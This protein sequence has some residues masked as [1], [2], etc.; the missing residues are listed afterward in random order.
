[1]ATLTAAE[2]KTILESPVSPGYPANQ[3]EEINAALMQNEERRKYPSIDVQNI[4]GQE[5]LKDFPTKTTGQTFL[6][7]LFYRYRSFGEQHEPDIKQYE[8][9]IFN[10]IDQAGDFAVPGVK[11][12][13]SQSWKRDSETFPVH[14]SHSILTVTAENIEATDGSGIPG[15]KIEI[16]IGGIGPLTVISLATDEKSINKQLDLKDDAER[17]FTKISNTDLLVVEVELTKS[18]EITMAGLV[19]AGDDIS[20]VLVKDGST[21]NL[22]ANLSNSIASASRD[23]VQ[24]T[25]VSMDIKN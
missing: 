4:T 13:V 18:T 23:V 8:D 22:T 2:I 9:A 20:V 21:Q 24:T 3:G 14:R 10:T 15:D 17:I 12:T 19:H 5:D 25:L 6:V 1:M 7:H 11:V 16:T